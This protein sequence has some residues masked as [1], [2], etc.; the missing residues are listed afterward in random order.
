MKKTVVHVLLSTACIILLSACGGGGGG[1]S[2]S[3]PG[4]GGGGSIDSAR[5]RESIRLGV[6]SLSSLLIS[7]V[8]NA[9]S[10]IN[11]AIN[12]LN[13]QNLSASVSSNYLINNSPH[14]MNASG[15]ALLYANNTPVNCD[16]FYS[17]NFAVD[18]AEAQGVGTI[19]G[20]E[21]NAAVNG[22]FTFTG[23]RGFLTRGDL[24]SGI[25]IADYFIING[26][27][28]IG[29]LQ[30]QGN[31]YADISG[32]VSNVRVSV[33]EAMNI[34]N[35]V[36]YGGAIN[37]GVAASVIKDGYINASSAD[38]Q[39]FTIHFNGSNLID[40]TASCITPSQFR[41]NVDTGQIM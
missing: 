11:S 31:Q 28:Q 3:N 21:L 26:N 13:C 25:Y 4:A 18:R 2:S 30:V 22:R 35:N 9:D 34:L 1:S 5:A 27:G 39:N 14:F 41:V 33:Y 32:N 17:G 37:M 16:Y 20:N 40:V 29:S 19:S 36:L 12:N 7:T 38:C 23:D 10:I 24:F 8:N 6:M 15:S